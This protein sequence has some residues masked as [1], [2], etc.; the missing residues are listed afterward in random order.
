MSAKKTPY[1]KEFIDKLRNYYINNN[2]TLAEMSKNSAALFGRDVS[3]PDLKWMSRDDVDYG[4]WSKLKPSKNIEDIP[5]KEKYA[6]VA[7]KIYGIIINEDD[8]IPTSQLA[9][10]AKTWSDLV[11]KSGMASEDSTAKTS[12]Q[13]AKDIFEKQVLKNKSK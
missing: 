8:P 5:I 2:T 10:L 13:Q 6:V 11:D 9:Q 4:P 12:T 1:K 3:L 7:N